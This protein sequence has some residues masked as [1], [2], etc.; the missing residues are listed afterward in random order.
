GDRRRTRPAALRC[1]ATTLPCRAA[2]RG[3][4]ARAAPRSEARSPPRPSAP[5]RRASPAG[6]VRHC[7]RARGRR[8]APAADRGVRSSAELGALALQRPDELVEGFAEGGHALFL[9][10]Q[11]DILHVDADGLQ[12]LEHA[13]GYVHALVDGAGDGPMVL[14]RLDGLLG[15][16]VDRI[17]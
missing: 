2:T 13:F 9:E 17:R 5:A 10:R 11:S 8:R 4:R 15:H 3:W 16:G 12:P 7:L 6:W 14:E 1:R